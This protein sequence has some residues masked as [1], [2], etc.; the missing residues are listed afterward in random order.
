MKLHYALISIAFLSG[1]SQAQSADPTLYVHAFRSP[2]TGLEY[3]HGNVGVHAGYYTTVLDGNGDST[4]FFKTGLTGYYRLSKSRNFDRF[5][6]YVSIAYVRG[7]N[8]DYE[9]KDGLFLE[10]GFSYDLGRNLE[11]RLGTGILAAKGR[12]TEVNPTIGL[13]YRN[14]IR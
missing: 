2:S 5:E 3:R 6:S 4:N 1:L 10:S 11:L 7:L 13:S 8:R 12:A 14:V 9:Q